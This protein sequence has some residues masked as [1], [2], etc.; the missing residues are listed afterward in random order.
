MLL[1]VVHSL[2]LRVGTG[3]CILSSGYRYIY[4]FGKQGYSE[5]PAIG[6]QS[7]LDEDPAAEVAWVRYEHKFFLTAKGEGFCEIRVRNCW[8][9]LRLPAGEAR[10]SPV[11]FDRARQ[12]TILTSELIFLVD[13]GQS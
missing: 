13:L 2:F 6:F 12:L 1:K 11:E 3:S 10:S 9:R 4:F 7:S 8:L 5:S